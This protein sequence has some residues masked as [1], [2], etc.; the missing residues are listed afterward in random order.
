MQDDRN[1]LATTYPHVLCTSLF[2]GRG[3][4]SPSALSIGQTCLL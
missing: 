1:I 3:S 2:C 4:D